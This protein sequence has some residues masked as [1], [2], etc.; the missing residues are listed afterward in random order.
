MYVV[1]NR[2][3]F[4]SLNLKHIFHIFNLLISVECVFD[5]ITAGLALEM[6]SDGS[7]TNVIYSCGVG[8]SMIGTP[9]ISCQP[10]GSLESSPPKCGRFTCYFSYV[11][12]YLVTLQNCHNYI[13]RSQL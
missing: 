4:I 3:S 10:N 12:A 6:V 8:Y 5:N 7:T 9:N 2:L 1:T 13:L 11:Y